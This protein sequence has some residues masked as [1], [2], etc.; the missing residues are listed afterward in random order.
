MQLLSRTL[1]AANV[2][3]MNG[4]RKSALCVAER[5]AAVCLGHG[6]ATGGAPPRGAHRSEIRWRKQQIQQGAGSWTALWRRGVPS[7]RGLRHLRLRLQTGVSAVAT[8]LH[9]TNGHRQLTVQLRVWPGTQ[10][11]PAACCSLAP[12][13]LKTCVI[14]VSA[15]QSTDYFAAQSSILLGIVDFACIKVAVCPYIYN[16]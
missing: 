12:A 14:R 9:P 13:N 5:A 2:Q 3:Q 10:V 16:I 11:H 7:R 4:V 15:M 8:P 1:L 6:A